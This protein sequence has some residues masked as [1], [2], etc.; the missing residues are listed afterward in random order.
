[1]WDIVTP[2]LL[3]H[4]RKAVL[5]LKDLQGSCS[6]STGLS[7]SGQLRQQGLRCR[8]VC[9]GAAGSHSLCVPRAGGGSKAR[10]RCWVRNWFA[11]FSAFSCRV[12]ALRESSQGLYSL[13][14]K[15]HSV[16]FGNLCS[17]DQE[18]ASN[19]C[20]PSIKEVKHKWFQVMILDFKQCHWR[21]IK[22][23]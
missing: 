4:A 14:V 9:R 18:L 21:Y 13:L 5:Y 3:P 22:N 15:F 16:V 10:W 20:C 8:W 7:S 17:V 1:M 12:L 23:F 19:W 2:W 6:S 11:P